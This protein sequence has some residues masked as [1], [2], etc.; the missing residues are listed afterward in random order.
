MQFLV[1]ST[2]KSLVILSRQLAQKSRKNICFI[3]S[4]SFT[5]A[6]KKGD[7]FYAQSWQKIG[8]K[9]DSE[10]KLNSL[11]FFPFYAI[12]RFLSFIQDS[13]CEWFPQETPRQI[14]DEIYEVSLHLHLK[15]LQSQSV[16]KNQDSKI[17]QSDRRGEKWKNTHLN[18]EFARIRN[19]KTSQHSNNKI[20]RLKIICSS[21]HRES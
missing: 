18:D 12:T 20:C 19:S 16:H 3:A 17:T 6:A 4:F 13:F 21:L 5:S 11:S 8:W 14:S 15:I 7:L 10:L 1:K 2:P 9:V